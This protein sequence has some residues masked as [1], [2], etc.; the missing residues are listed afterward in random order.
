MA[1][2]LSR[3][4]RGA[5]IQAAKSEGWLWGEKRGLA[6][7]LSLSPASLYLLHFCLTCLSLFVQHLSSLWS[8]LLASNLLAFSL[9]ASGLLAS[10]LPAFSL[11][12]SSQL[13]SS[14]FPS[15]VL[16]FNLLSSNPL[17]AGGIQ[18][19]STHSPCIPSP[20]QYL[21]PVTGSNI[22]SQFGGITLHPISSHDLA[23]SFMACSCLQSRGRRRSSNSG[24]RSGRVSIQPARF[25]TPC[26]QA[27]SIQLGR[28]Q[29]PCI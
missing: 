10:N 21:L 3:T 4:P 16:A 2:F 7:R 22:G 29:P 6:L 23:F 5:R 26:I 19:H 8:C 18:H 15:P 20:P 17:S 9:L 28:I 27:L 12:A 1:S 13:A 25:G 14:P 24:G 11:L